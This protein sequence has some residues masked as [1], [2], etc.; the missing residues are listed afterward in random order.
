MTRTWVCLTLTAVLW[1]GAALGQSPALIAGIRAELRPYSFHQPVGH[2]VWVRFS[3]ENT[4]SEALTLTVPGTKPAIPSPE[5]GLPLS[6]VFSGQSNSGVTVISPSGRRWDEPIGYRSPSEAPILMIA[7]HGSVGVTLDLREYF[8]ALRGAGRFR[9]SWAPYAGGLVTD[10]FVL[11]IAALKQ[12]EVVTDLGTMTV[13][14]LYADAPKHV[15]NFIDLAQSGFYNGKMFHRLEP[16]YLIQ[17]GCPRGDGTG[18]RPDGKRL[19]AEF[20]GHPMLKGT[21]AMA[22]LAD[23]PDSASCQ[24]FICNTR[25]KEWDGRYTVFG[26]L[27]GDESYATLDKLMA[28]PVDEAGRP[29]RPIYMRTVRIIDAPPDTLP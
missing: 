24:F 13:R 3:L 20:N 18:I 12:A 26:D 25:Q 29:E 5:A 15:A 14:L 8:P 10:S 11:S 27:V 23:D 1:S 7:P 22:L 2:P 21:L 19:L 28:T 6:H 17:G 4:T 9:I 16:G